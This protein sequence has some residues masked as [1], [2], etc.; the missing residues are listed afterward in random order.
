M[1]SGPATPVA[2]ADCGSVVEVV[3]LL[4]EQIRRESA[5]AAGRNRKLECCPRCWA[6]MAAGC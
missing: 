2:L 4:H 3:S 6:T 1:P 5:D